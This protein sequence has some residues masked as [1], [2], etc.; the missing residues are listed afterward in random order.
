MITC[1]ERIGWEE[2]EIFIIGTVLLICL[3]ERLPLPV[4]YT[5][6]SVFDDTT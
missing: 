2:L 1:K 6:P 3:N 4:S 5:L